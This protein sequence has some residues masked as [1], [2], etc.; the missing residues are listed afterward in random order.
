MVFAFTF[1]GEFGYELMNWQGVI[2]KFSRTLDEADHIV[3]C[4]RANVY[5]IYEMADAYVDI[6]EV[7][8][9]KHSRAC[10]YSGT[11]GAG[12]PRRSLNRAF[13]SA[14]RASLR[15]FIRKKI[16]ALEPAWKG[17]AGRELTFVFSSK[18]TKVRGFTFGCDPE[19]IE[20]EADIY[21]QL[22]LEA[23]VFA[24]IRPDLR[25]RN[26]IERRLGFD[27]SEPYV[28]FQTRARMVGPRSPAIQKG[29]LI[30][31]V[32][33]RMPVVL[34]SFD[35]GR[36]FESSSRFD[37]SL[38]CLHY[39]GR[40][41]PEQACLIEFARRC[42]FFTEGDFGSHIYVPPLMG[43]NVV[44]IAPASVYALGT[45]P[46]DF[47]NRNV[48]CFGGRIVPKVSEDALASERST[49]EL[50]DEIVSACARGPISDSS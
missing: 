37:P 23:N 30:R 26:Q 27:L 46:A 38:R 24:K 48:F 49:R 34:L 18:K 16:R 35:T 25:V 43:K 1:L 39:G 22:D 45:A 10:C 15:S 9:F 3:C 50:A 17:A 29:G 11:V 7:R 47:W 6:S 40:S 13:D 41:F 20:E 28:L 12:A 21:D 4:S 2:R 14:L 44:A 19:R 31:E 36:A 33:K 5:P 8:L 32:A 42:V